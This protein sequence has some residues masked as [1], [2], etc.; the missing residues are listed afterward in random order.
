MKDARCN[1][2]SV[3][4]TAVGHVLSWTRYPKLTSQSNTVTWLHEIRQVPEHDGLLSTD[5][6][7]G[8]QAAEALFAYIIH[9]EFN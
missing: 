9:K 2:T 1:R 6:M 3:L 8:A 4:Y 7:M 5:R